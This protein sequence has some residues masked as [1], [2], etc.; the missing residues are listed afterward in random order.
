LPP[1]LAGRSGGYKKSG[2]SRNIRLKPMEFLPLVTTGFSP[3]QFTTPQYL[4]K[5]LTASSHAAKVV[6]AS[7]SKIS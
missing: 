2:F 4:A 3:W 5:E 7:P 1:A 6:E